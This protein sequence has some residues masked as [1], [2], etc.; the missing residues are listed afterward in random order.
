M[1]WKNEG[2][3]GDEDRWM[4]AY[5]CLATKGNCPSLTSV[6]VY[7]CVCVCRGRG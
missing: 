7:V 3:E 4:D 2:V 1:W 5:F 6:Y